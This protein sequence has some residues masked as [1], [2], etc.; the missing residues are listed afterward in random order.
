M[1]ATDVSTEPAG[2]KDQNDDDDL[3]HYWDTR[4]RGG[5]TISQASNRPSSVGT[6]P[7]IG[8]DECD[9]QRGQKTRAHETG[10][11]DDLVQ[12]IFQNRWDGEGI[13]RDGGLVESEGEWRIARSDPIGMDVDDES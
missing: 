9:Q 8:S 2:K 4:R 5:T 11:G 3:E 1:Y 10:S 6:D 12:W 7:A 13:T